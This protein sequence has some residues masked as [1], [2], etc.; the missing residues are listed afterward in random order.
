MTDL[1]EVSVAGETK[2]PEKKPTF[3]SF[4]SPKIPVAKLITRGEESAICHHKGTVAKV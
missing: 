2:V 1:Q 4:H 3:V